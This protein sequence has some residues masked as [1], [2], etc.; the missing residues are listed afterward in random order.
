MS[1]VS[2]VIVARQ[3][4]PQPLGSMLAWSALAHLGLLAV[5]IFGPDWRLGAEEP[6][7]TVM[8]I[9]LGGA[10]GPRAGGMTSMGGRAIPPPQPDT[11]PRAMP[12]PP[13]RPVE[14][15]V[16]T[17]TTPPP[18]RPVERTTP[19]ETATRRP[20][21]APPP[22]EEPQPGVTRTE[23]G[24][25]GQGFGLSTGGAG[26]S[27]VQL[28]VSDFCCPEYIEQMVR[29]IQDNWQQSQGVRGATVMKFT[30]T[31]PGAIRDVA[32]E[33]PSGFLALDLSAERALLRTQLPPLP[34][35]FPNST[36]TVHITFEYQQ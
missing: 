25:R 2:D 20:R 8:T 29:L 35:S 21:A 30:I 26:G 7:K 5:A 22:T 3:R 18:P 15:T 33:R 23:T 36:L 27:G 31:R 19:A 9:S 17:E 11:T 24:A 28:D 10:P 14:R 12:P 16:P 1:A 34:A 13:P 4:Q 6:P 32:I